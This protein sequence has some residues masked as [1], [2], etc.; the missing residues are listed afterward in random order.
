MKKQIIKHTRGLVP[1]RPETLQ[2]DDK[3]YKTWF[4]GT[5]YPSEY[6][7]TEDT[8]QANDLT[9]VRIAHDTFDLYHADVGPYVDGTIY[10]EESQFE[11]QT[12]GDN[13]GKFDKA[14]HKNYITKN[15]FRFARPTLSKEGGDERT[16]SS[17]YIEL[18]LQEPNCV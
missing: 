3:I 10:C 5:L 8:L 15:T 7:L 16:E 12:L 14:Y 18:I 13:G 4:Y 2:I 9:L 6:S 1:E 11:N 17:R